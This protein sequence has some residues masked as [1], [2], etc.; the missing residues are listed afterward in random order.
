MVNQICIAGLLQGLS[1]AIYFGEKS[2]I[3]MKK[4]MA[5]I[6]KGAAGSWQMENRAETMIE[7][8][9]DFGFALKWMR[10]DLAF[11]LDEAEEKNIAL[12]ITQ[13]VDKYYALLEKDGKDRWDTSALIEN[14][15]QNKI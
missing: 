4:V 7:G 3:N 8:K 2:G 13:L 9:F 10:K 15:R 11:C 1:E 6:G 14:L 12:P 5:T